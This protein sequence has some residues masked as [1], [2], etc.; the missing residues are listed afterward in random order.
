VKVLFI[1]HRLPY[2]PN[3]GD[4]IRAYHTLREMSKWAEVHLC[5]LVHDDEEASHTE[6]L[7]SLV[8]SVTIARVPRVRNHLRAGLALGSSTPLTHILLDAPELA[9]A[10]DQLAVTQRPDIVYCFCTGVG[11]VALRPS[12]A[13]IPIVLDMVDVDSIKWSALAQSCGFPMSWVY[14]REA[15]C[16][17]RFESAIAMRAA[18]T[19]LTTEA[20]RSDLQKIAPDARVVVIG[21]GVD[22]DYYRRP[23]PHEKPANPTVIFCGVMNYAPNTE[24]IQWFV[25]DVWPAVR[26]KLPRAELKIVGASPTGAVKNLKDRAK[27]IAVTGTVPDV[28]PFLWASSVA[29]APL[30][31]ARGVQNKVLESIAAGLT[32]VVTPAVAKGLPAELSECFRVAATSEEFADAV[33]T[34]V[35]AGHDERTAELLRGMSWE[36][37][38]RQ[39]RPLLESALGHT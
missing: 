29:I 25:K 28:R 4:R 10:V 37:R 13:G 22:R 34:E 1:S 3:R 30:M 27:G 16:L 31:T 20:E 18:V 24:G 9:A 17:S 35:T 32:A 23:L 7:R 26:A 15:R 2:A 21:V 33:V 14:G 38:L 19:I 8:R 39:L 36:P 11:P 6:D 12:L 5:A